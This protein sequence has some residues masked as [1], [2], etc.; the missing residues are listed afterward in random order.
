MAKRPPKL[1]KSLKLER[2]GAIAIVTLARPEKRNA[3][4]DTTV[5]G[6]E[7]LYGAASQRRSDVLLPG[8]SRKASRINGLQKNLDV[9]ESNHFRQKCESLYLYRIFFSIKE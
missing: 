4:N 5:R 8:G 7:T 2:R 9:V 3:L 1:P 6:L